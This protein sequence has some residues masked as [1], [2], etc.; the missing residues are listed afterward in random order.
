MSNIAAPDIATPMN[1]LYASK[2]QLLETVQQFPDAALDFVVLVAGAFET[3]SLDAAQPLLDACARALKSGGLL[4][5][6]GRVDQLPALGV[7]LDSQLTFKYWLAVA[8]EPYRPSSGL[9]SAHAGILLFVKGAR[10][11]IQKVRFPHEH[12]AFC[13][14]TLRDWGGK[15]H[16][17]HP[18]G[19]MISDVWKGLPPENNYTQL[20]DTVLQTL[21][22]LLPP[23]DNLKGVIGPS[24]GVATLVASK[25]AEPAPHY[26]LPLFQQRVPKP[27]PAITQPAAP[28]LWDAVITGDAIQA[29][30]RYPDASVDLVFA[31]P[32]YNLDKAYSNYADGRQVEAYLSW[33]NAW[34]DEYT[35]I[36]KPTGSL[37]VL[38]LPHWA[39]YHAAHLNQR[40]YF[41][42][43]IV[44]D[45][46]SEPRGKLM[47]AHYALLF[48]TKQPTEF[49]FNYTA[50]GEIDSRRYCLRQSCVRERKRAGA[51]AK[52]P[53][54]DIWTDVHR[55]KHRRDRDYH[56]C[57]LPD[58][59]L[60]R[61][62]RLSTNP[63]D[64][65]VDA[66][67]GA[68]TAVVIAAQLK[69]RYV[70]IDIDENYTRIIRDKLAQV[71]VQGQV[72]RTPVAQRSTSP[73]SK[74]ALQLEL[75]TIAEKLGRLPTPEDVQALSRYD[76]D[77]FLTTFATW[78][79]ALKA[80][81]IEFNSEGNIGYV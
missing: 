65:V 73:Y 79:K 76:V 58:A 28:E 55:I 18:D 5:V 25:V 19:Y 44:W 66:L 50:L 81:K 40:L 68:G 64:I 36:L 77:A 32:P 63:G 27:A 54:T 9:P 8:S 42:N 70:A 75:K 74:K 61:I 12:C 52:D 6:Q 45:A 49:T 21:L 78:G 47:P 2:E 29:L 51:D 16:L 38:N 20:S 69:R 30:Q 39:M 43:W 41:Q 48:Y 34:L 46:L 17:M 59:L 31:D 4:F 1:I 23:R 72:Q 7:Y 13:E 10:F 62:I 26:Q 80:A 67:A 15:A 3:F 56:P 24:D 14:R 57:Q 71:E 22:R 37:Y 11:E 33:C 53:L 35:R 60:E